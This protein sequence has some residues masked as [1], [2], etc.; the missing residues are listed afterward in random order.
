MKATTT[1][2][3]STRLVGTLRPKASPSH[4]THTTFAEK[5]IEG[6]RSPQIRPLYREILAISHGQIVVRKRHKTT[7]GH[8]QH[9]KV[10][11]PQTAARVT[12][13]DLVIIGAG[14]YGLSIAAHLRETKSTFRVFGTPMQNCRRHKPKGTLLKPD[15]FASSLHDPHSAFAL[16]HPCEDM[17]LPHAEVGLP[18]PLQVVFGN[19]LEFQ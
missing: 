2:H 3:I 14:S 16:R 12:M 10:N 6:H 8:T 17:K 11:S 19:G 7:G 15:G 5:S 18:V 13:I 4:S 9:V 1:S